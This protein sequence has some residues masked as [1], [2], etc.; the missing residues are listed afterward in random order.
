MVPKQGFRLANLG[1]EKKLFE[2]PKVTE[3][4]WDLHVEAM[5]W[6][7]TP[8]LDYLAWSVGLKS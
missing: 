5:G 2:N 6:D 7:V 1:P 8:M 3:L 4:G